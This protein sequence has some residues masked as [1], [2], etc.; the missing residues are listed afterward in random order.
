MM[1]ARTTYGLA[2]SAAA[3]LVLTSV[4]AANTAVDTWVDRIS[5][6]PTPNRETLPVDRYTEILPSAEAGDRDAHRL[7]HRK[8]R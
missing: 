3:L 1:K 5:V 6:I 8:G 2:L 4:Y 7:R